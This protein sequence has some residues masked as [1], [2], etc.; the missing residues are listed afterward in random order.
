M[1]NKDSN[2][3]DDYDDRLGPELEYIAKLFAHEKKQNDKFILYIDSIIENSLSGENNIEKYNPSTMQKVIDTKVNCKCCPRHQIN[4]PT[5]YAPW[6]ELP[7]RGTQDNLCSCTC[8]HEARMICR[9][10]PEYNP[11]S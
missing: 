1:Q 10:H 9:S 5:Q 8:R 11:N 2:T 6:I 3:T 4:K 7:F